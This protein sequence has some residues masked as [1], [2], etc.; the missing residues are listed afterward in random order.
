MR[1][2]DKGIELI[3]ISRVIEMWLI[4]AQVANGL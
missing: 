1:I 4:Y 3:N 2:A